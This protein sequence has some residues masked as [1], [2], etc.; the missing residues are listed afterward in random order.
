MANK[1][2]CNFIY[3]GSAQTELSSMKASSKDGESLMHKVHKQA[4]K[5]LW[6]HRAL[7]VTHSLFVQR[8]HTKL[9]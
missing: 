6:L 2:E 9:C 1:T 4:G 5:S 8:M 7:I 3:T